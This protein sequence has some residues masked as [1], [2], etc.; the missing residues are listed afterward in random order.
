MLKVEGVGTAAA[1][2]SKAAGSTAA[3]CMVVLM[4]GPY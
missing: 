1:A 2:G 4:P 3:V